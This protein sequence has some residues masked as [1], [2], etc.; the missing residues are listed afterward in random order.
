MVGVTPYDIDINSSKQN[1]YGWYFYCKN[2][3]LYSGPP[4]K[5][6]NKNSGLKNKR[7]EIIVIMNMKQKSLKFIIDNEDKGESYTNIPID[8][9][10]SP[11]VFI[12]DKNDSVE[13]TEY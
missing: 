6:R 7:N 5:Y 9:P 13:I 4:H 8:K 1:S 2:A 11:A 12:L 3:G 10:L